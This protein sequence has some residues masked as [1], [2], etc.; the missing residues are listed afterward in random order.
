MEQPA[1]EQQEQKY[2]PLMISYFRCPMG[3][4]REAE[5]CRAA[6]ASHIPEEDQAA[7][8]QIPIHTHAGLSGWRMQAVAPDDAVQ[9]MVNIKTLDIRWV[10]Y[11]PISDE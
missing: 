3:R 8:I 6:L 10:N 5:I 1:P 7:F 9:F 4:V 11:E 2:P